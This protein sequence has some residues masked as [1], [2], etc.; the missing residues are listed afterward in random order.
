MKSLKDGWSIT[1]FG[2]NPWKVGKADY[3]EKLFLKNVFGS[4]VRED[5]VSNQ[6]IGRLCKGL[7]P[8]EAS[9]KTVFEAAAKRGRKPKVSGFGTTSRVT[10]PSLEA[11]QRFLNSQNKNDDPRISYRNQLLE[12]TDLLEK[13]ALE[14]MSEPEIRIFSKVKDCRLKSSDP[15]GTD[16]DQFIVRRR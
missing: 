4:R 16:I 3:R 13:K 2:L 6:G 1:G 12:A 15:E 8:F 9:S 5:I 7:N 14:M 11:H 10:I